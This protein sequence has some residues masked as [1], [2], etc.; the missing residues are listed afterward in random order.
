MSMGFPPFTRAVKWLV[1]I[2][3]AVY[4]LMLILEAVAP[5]AGGPDHRP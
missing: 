5:A 4:L 3:A 1:I 2:N